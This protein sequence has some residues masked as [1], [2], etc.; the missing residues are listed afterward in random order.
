MST[1]KAQKGRDAKQALK[2]EPGVL[3]ECKWLRDGLLRTRPPVARC[4]SLTVCR[5]V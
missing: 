4:A 2:L 1:K 3:V 5:R